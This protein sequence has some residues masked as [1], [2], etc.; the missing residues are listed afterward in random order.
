MYRVLT[1][2]GLSVLALLSIGVLVLASAGSENGIR[3]YGNPYHFVTRQAVWLVAALVA[4]AIA[5]CFDYHKWREYPWLTIAFYVGVILLMSAVFLF[6]EVNG[7]RRWLIFGPIRLQPSELGKLAVVIVTAVFL[8]RTGWLVAKFWK[9]AF[10]AVLIVGVLMGLAVLEP[11]FG[12][13][14]VIAGTAAVMFLVSGM[15]IWHMIT[16]GVLGSIPVLA[17][18]ATNKNR[19]NRI[20]SWLNSMFGQAMSDGG[21]V[22]ELSAK[23]KAAAHQIEMALVAM[24]NGGA[25]GVGFNNSYQK[26]KYLPEAHTDCIF[27]VG[28]EEW[29]L[30]FSLL[31][32]ALYVTILVCG[33]IIAVRSDR[34]GRLMAYG[35]TFLLV[36]QA[37]FNIGVVTK[38]FPTKGI[39]LPF[40]SY[41]GTNLISALVAIGVLFN[42]GR[43]IELPKLRPRSTISPVFEPEPEGV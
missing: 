30:I 23:E 33:I 1:F 8:D 41:G 11:D 6:R 2:L 36:F 31:L 10:R 17:L 42:I 16:L 35:M 39:A 29:G 40:I 24:R 20:F 18:L 38:C 34:L 25:T 37:F 43:Q 14:M 28:A 13:T 12:A 19:M 5:A 32:V 26:L 9:G 4:M 15:K 3:F 22:V 7:S 27:A 21:M